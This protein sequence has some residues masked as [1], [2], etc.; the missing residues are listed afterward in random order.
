MFDKYFREKYLIKVGLN[1]T[2]ITVAPSP[3]MTVS[4][5]E[6]FSKSRLFVSH[7]KTIMSSCTE[8]CC[9]AKKWEKKIIIKKNLKK[10]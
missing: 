2:N 4:P 10:K 3:A 6:I 7:N 9:K 1:Q 8:C 5:F